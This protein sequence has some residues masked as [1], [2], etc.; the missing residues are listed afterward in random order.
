[1]TK[2]SKDSKDELRKSLDGSGNNTKSPETVLRVR[3]GKK[4]LIIRINK[5]SDTSY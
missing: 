3:T 4:K 5:I 2:K 1:M